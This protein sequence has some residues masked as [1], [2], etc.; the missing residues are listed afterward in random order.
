MNQAKQ[1][2]LGAIGP[3]QPSLCI[4]GSL[5]EETHTREGAEQLQP[6]DGLQKVSPKQE[7]AVLY[8]PKCL[9]NEIRC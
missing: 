8:F 5:L 2:L 3:S 9:S 1:V 4:I 7:S 6:L